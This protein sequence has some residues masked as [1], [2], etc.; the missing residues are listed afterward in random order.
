[1]ASRIDKVEIAWGA[2]FSTPE[3]SRLWINVSSDFLLSAGA[4]ITYGRSDEQSQ[5]T[6][7]TCTLTLENVLGDYT[8]G[9]TSSGFYPNVVKGVPIRVSVV[10]AGTTYVRFTGYV[11]EW[12][13]VWPTGGDTYSTVTITASSRRARLGQT[14]PLPSAIR[15]AYL[16]TEPR[17][18]WPMDEDTDSFDRDGR[19]TFSD[20]TNTDLAGSAPELISAFTISDA[21]APVVRDG[22]AGPTDEESL[23]RFPRFTNSALVATFPHYVGAGT[24]IRLLPSD[25]ITVQAVARVQATAEG[26]TLTTIMELRSS[27]LNDTIALTVSSDGAGAFSEVVAEMVTRNH[28]TGALIEDKTSAGFTTGTYRPDLFAAATDGQI[29]HYAFTLDPDGKTGRFYFDGSLF[30]SLTFTTG[31]FSQ[32]ISGIAFGADTY[33]SIAW[34]GHGAVHARALSAAE[35]A[36]VAAAATAASETIPE[37]VIRLA[38]Y[39]GIP[40]DEV[41]VEASVAAPPGPQA[42]KDRTVVDVLDEL[43]QSTGG[44]LY[45]G[46]DGHLTM[47]AR[48]HRYNAASALTLSAAA[49]EIE[50]DLT[51]TLDDRYLINRVELTRTGATQ[52][53]PRVMTDDVSIDAYGIYSTSVQMVSSNDD[54]LEGRGTDLLYRYAEPEVRISQV[55][56]N[57]GD[58]A[59]T[60]IL[61]GVGLYGAGI[62][63]GA[64]QQQLALPIDIGS[65]ITLTNLPTQA[66]APSMDLFVEGYTETISLAGHSITF[67]TTP[68]AAYQHIFTLDDP[69]RGV[70]DAGNVIAY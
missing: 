62:Y 70:L 69:V 32:L 48:N 1:V 52:A 45:D 43:A 5:P 33:N 17:A 20:V 8:P 15:A 27:D 58:L 68:A 49:D 25:G 40:A 55:T 36:T 41:D 57:I 12:P 13:I 60:T 30:T 4:T 46:R 31:A 11:N 18:Y 7:N 51:A 53:S 66:P 47:Q 42:E 3:A 28:D 54:E 14:A 22:T 65:K 64:T 9:N 61:Y 6:P 35:I 34:I 29:H 63:P 39:L 59:G 38:T 19:Q 2:G 56:V 26:L 16:A 67:N 21:L 10:Y 50:A 24:A 37:R 44:V 23:V